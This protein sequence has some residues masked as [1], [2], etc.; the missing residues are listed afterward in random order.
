[1]LHWIKVVIRVLI[2]KFSTYLFA[3]HFVWRIY[4]INLNSFIILHMCTCQNVKEAGCC[5]NMT[6]RAL[7]NAMATR[8]FKGMGISLQDTD[9]R[10]S[11]GPNLQMAGQFIAGWHQPI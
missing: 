4:T 8:V 9:S 3:Q 11:K 7:T 6:Y 5:E 10:T 2:I 1:M